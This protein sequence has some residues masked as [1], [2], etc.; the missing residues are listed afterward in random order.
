MHHLGQMIHQ[1]EI[2]IEVWLVSHLAHFS[3]N[4]LA[5]RYVRKKQ[6]PDGLNHR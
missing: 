3:I 1:Y 4:R 6:D 5:A 2:A